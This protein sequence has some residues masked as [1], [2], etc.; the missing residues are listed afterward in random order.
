[1]EGTYAE[2]VNQESQLWLC[3]SPEEAFNLAGLRFSSPYEMRDQ[4]EMESFQ[5][6]KCHTWFIWDNHEHPM[7]S[8]GKGDKVNTYELHP[9]PDHA[10]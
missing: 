3:P 8:I 9:A 4:E 5:L 2:T 6:L 10:V 7:Q 1:M